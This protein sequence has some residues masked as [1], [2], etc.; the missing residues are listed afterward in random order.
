MQCFNKMEL[1][2]TLLFVL[3]SFEIRNFLTD[4]LEEMLLFCHTLFTT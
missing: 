4:E 3:D 2:A 1:F